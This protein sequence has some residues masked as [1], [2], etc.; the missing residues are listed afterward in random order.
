MKATELAVKLAFVESENSKLKQ[1]LEMIDNAIDPY[2]DQG[3]CLWV[4]QSILKEY[5]S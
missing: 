3:E 5:K 4:I 1:Y 2:C